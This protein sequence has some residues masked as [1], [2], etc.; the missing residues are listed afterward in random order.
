MESVE[1]TSISIEIDSTN[2]VVIQTFCCLT[3]EV[4]NTGI[5]LRMRGNSRYEINHVLKPKLRSKTP[6]PSGVYN[7]LKRHNMN[8]LSER[9]KEKKRKIVSRKAGELGHI[10]CHYLSKDVVPN[11]GKR[12]YLTCLV[13]G[14]SRIAWAEVVEDL[15]S[16]TVMFATL[17]SLN[18]LNDRYS[19]K[20]ESVLTDNGAEFGSGR[21][22]KNKESNAFERMLMELGIKHKY[23]RPYRPQTNGKAER[24]WKTLKEDMLEGAEYETKEK[25][26]EELL[27]YL[28][29]Y[30]EHR[31]H[32]AIGGE[33]PYSY[34]NSLPN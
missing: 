27:N 9:M 28:V 2:Q 11:S 24:F 26:E 19:I 3:K 30:N 17:R 15:K 14:C 22:T 23:T 7:I 31:P 29:Y 20:F 4:P 18:M 10:D 25:L 16:I 21:Y 32:Q 6:S 33:T 34:L 8:R 5:E 1:R 13:D 12:L